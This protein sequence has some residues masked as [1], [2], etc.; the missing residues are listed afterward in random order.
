L[1][2]PTEKILF[3]YTLVEGKF[4]GLPPQTEGENIS[5]PLFPEILIALDAIFYKKK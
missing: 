3:V 1:D 5:S 2:N 4:I